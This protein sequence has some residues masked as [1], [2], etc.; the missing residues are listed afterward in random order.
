MIQCQNCGFENQPGHI[1][2]IGCRKKLDLSQVSTVELLKSPGIHRRVFKSIGW[3]LGLLFLVMI[4]LALWPARPDYHRGNVAVD[5]LEARR[6]FALMT[7]TNKLTV[8]V[9][10]EAEVNACLAKGIK[11]AGIR[12]DRGI[13]RRW[14]YSAGVVLMP[15]YMVLCVVGQLESVEV[16]SVDLGLKFSYE[17]AMLPGVEE[18]GIVFSVRSG[19]LGHL[20]LPRLA[21]RLLVP[22]ATALFSEMKDEC[23]WLTKVITV[24]L[25]EGRVT[26]ALKR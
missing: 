16:R 26:L 1:F 19:K 6:K 21:A 3:V 13:L 5:Y 12:P 22:Q 15:D 18:D 7:G 25:D 14:H 23:P 2:C 24:Q 17:L 9:F 11:M 8:Q 4:A 20:P 10:S